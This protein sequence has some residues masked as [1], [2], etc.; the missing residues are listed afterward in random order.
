MGHQ[1]AMRQVSYTS[2]RGIGPYLFTPRA[3]KGIDLG[4]PGKPAASFK[5]VASI[6]GLDWSLLG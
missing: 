3:D 2:P 6:G 1:G 5:L 4:L